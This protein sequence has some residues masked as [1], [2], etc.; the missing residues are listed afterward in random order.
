MKK[1]LE[2]ILVNIWKDLVTL[3]LFFA[4]LGLFL[5]GAFGLV[6]VGE[7]MGL[8]VIPITHQPVEQS[9][10]SAL[11]ALFK[12]LISLFLSYHAFKNAKFFEYLR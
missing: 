9:F 5:F 6:V 4:G 2:S 7:F 11:T 1:F 8:Y 3:F 12:S 10:W